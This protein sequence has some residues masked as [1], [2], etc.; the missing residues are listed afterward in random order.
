MARIDPVTGQVI[1]DAGNQLQV[2]QSALSPEF[3]QGLQLEGNVGDLTRD[4]LTQN[5][6]DALNRQNLFNP[7]AREVSQSLQGQTPLP[8]TEDV[9]ID[10]S[11]MQQL[12]TGFSEEEPLGETPAG[13]TGDVA[14]AVTTKPTKPRPAAPAPQTRE[15]AAT[16]PVWQQLLNSSYDLTDAA[17]IGDVKN[18]S[19][20]AKTVGALR[21]SLVD[22]EEQANVRRQEI[23]LRRDKA[24]REER[25]KEQELLSKI[26]SFRV[27]PENFF[28]SRGNGARIFAALAVGLGELG[29]SMAG[30]GTNAALQIIDSAIARDMEAQKIRLNQLGSAADRQRNRISDLTA[31]FDTEEQREAASLVARYR[32]VE[33][34]IAAATEGLKGEQAKTRGMA[35]MAGVQERRAGVQQQLAL[36]RERAAALRAMSG[37]GPVDLSAL[38]PDEQK[39]FVPGLNVVAANEKEREK[40]INA[41]QGLDEAERVIGELLQLRK[42]FGGGLAVTGKAR[43]AKAKAKALST[44]LLLSLKNVYELGVLSKSD[45]E[46]LNRLVPGDPLAFFS[47]DPTVMAKLNEARKSAREKYRSELSRRGFGKQAERVLFGGSSLRPAGE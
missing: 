39:R 31:Q 18:L 17:I 35:L 34:K 11:L 30:G 9:P 19:K 23:Q 21:S 6:A 38:T 1:T 8:P 40:I 25:A 20:H 43:E 28:T 32:V 13:P 7:I 24:I 16:Q 37:G 10:P 12:E 5:E 29:R 45:E 27:D 22:A 3:L 15:E 44:Q 41:S 33:N 2:A 42:D 47:T 46:L 36:A 14:A 26:D 4:Q